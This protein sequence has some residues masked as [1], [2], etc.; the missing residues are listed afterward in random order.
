MSAVASPLLSRDA[1]RALIAVELVCRKSGQPPTWAELGAMLGWPRE[2][3]AAR[4]RALRPEG[5]RWRRHEERSLS[6][7]GW[8][9]ERA[10]HAVREQNGPAEEKTVLSASNACSDA[11]ATG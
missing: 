2:E 11:G 6:A 3:V 1:A 5:L 7:P 8:A 10:M 4:I 9:L